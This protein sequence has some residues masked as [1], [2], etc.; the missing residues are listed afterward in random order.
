MSISVITPVW[1]RADLTLR[2]LYQNHQLY[3]NKPDVKFIIIDNGSTDGTATLLKSWQARFGEQMAVI[4]NAE[5]RGF[6]PA[7]NQAAE[8]AKGDTLLFLNN[9]II[10]NGDYLSLIRKAVD[11]KTLV[12]A[13][14]LDFDTGWNVFDGQIISYIHGWC[15]AMTKAAFEDLGGFD[16]RYIPGDYED[17]DLCYTATQAGYELKSVSLPLV[18]I[19]EQ[20]SKQLGDRRSM[21]LKHKALFAEK[22]GLKC[23]LQTSKA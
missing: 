11:D 3:H 16:E 14:L 17:V 2:Y 7:N 15:L 13:E 18:H 5:N 6:G 21:T 20:T 1:N 4:S 8:I 10:I 23:E 22:W 12:G 19:F 9:D